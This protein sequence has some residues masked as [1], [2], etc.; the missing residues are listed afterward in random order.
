MK[1]VARHHLTTTG[2]RRCVGPPRQTNGGMESINTL[3]QAVNCKALGYR[4]FETIVTVIL[5][6]AGKLGYSQT[7]PYL[8]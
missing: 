8:R 5:L 4:L 2:G 7:N 6:L 1:A 3:F